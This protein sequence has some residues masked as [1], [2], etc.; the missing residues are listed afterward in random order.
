MGEGP[1]ERLLALYIAWHGDVAGLGRFIL[2]QVSDVSVQQVRDVGVA[3]DTA[4]LLDAISER[5]KTS[6]STFVDFA[7][8][9]A[10]RVKPVELG[11]HT[12]GRQSR[13]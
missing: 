3:F 9:H 13:A 11:G 4:G 10:P 5:Q 12:K 2:L 8:Y 1:E 7:G 6:C